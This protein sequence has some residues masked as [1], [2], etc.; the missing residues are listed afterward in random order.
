MAIKVVDEKFSARFERE[1]RAIAALN[2]PHICTLYDVGPNYLVM[3]VCEGETLAARL[4]RGKFS[5]EDTVHFGAQIA[6]ALSAAHAKG[7][8][9]RDLKPGNIMISKSGVK[10]LDFGLAKTQHDTTITA[11]NVVTGTPAYMAPEQREGKECDARTDIYSLGLVLYEMASGKRAE[12]GQ[13]PP[14]EHLPEKLAHVIGLCIAPEPED[15]WQSTADLCRE[16]QWIED[17]GANAATPAHAVTRGKLR[18]KLLWG[19][20]AA[21][22]VSLALLAFLYFRENPPAPAV[23]LR[24]QV[25]LSEN[26]ISFPVLSPD[27]GRVVYLSEGRLW[28]L[29]LATGESRDLAAADGASP[30]WSPDSRFIGYISEK[31]LTTIEAIGGP[32]QTVTDRPGNSV[33]GGGAWNR[34]DMIVFGDRP[35]G[36]F[37]VAA[38]GGIPVQITAVNAAH[39]NSQYDPSFLPDGRHF[40]YFRSSSEG[41]SAVYLGSLDAKPEQQSSKALVASN[42]QALYVPSAD[43]STGSGYLLFVRGVT[44]MA[45]PFDNRRLELKGQAA[46]LAEQVKPIS[47]DAGHLVFSASP[48]VLVLPRRFATSQLSWFDRQGKVMGTVGDPGVYY[49]LELSPDETRLAVT[50]SPTADASNIWLLDLS[51]GGASTRFTFGSPVDTD[52]VWSPD[53]SRIIFSSNRE[54]PF[55][56]YQQPANGVNDEL[57]L[58]SNEN[59]FAESW[60]RD[61]RFLLYTVID[62]KTKGDLWVLP[63]GKDKKPVPFL[64]T[65]FNE[66]Q[67][68]FSPDGHWVAY[69]S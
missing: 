69:T 21:L 40:V 7:I 39:E 62:P 13:T 15:R 35:V 68:R 6:S 54:G 38:S 14:M 53:G 46:P 5:M 20:A 50:K 17:Q 32:P 27:G 45:Q 37:R 28:V 41:N 11:T 63:L 19:S 64:T 42:S 60:S 23:P 26:P 33:W 36:M 1:A 43:P 58:K 47:P 61:G 18:E 66:T 65:E 31:K 49:N 25:Q 52:P 2:H 10:V 57:V 48:N 29:S 67:A 30:F 24:F 59:K 34:E 16:L 12:Q 22:A 4:K 9:H 56:L 8:V 3:E 44:L 55:N 51:R